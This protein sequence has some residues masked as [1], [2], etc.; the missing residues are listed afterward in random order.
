MAAKIFRSY[1][2]ST[3]TSSIQPSCNKHH[4]V[5]AIVIIIIITNDDD[6]DDDDFYII[7]AVW[8]GCSS[9]LYSVSPS[10]LYSKD[11]VVSP[12]SG[13]FCKIRSLDG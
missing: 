11:F 7:G 9:F 6:D 13:H 5:I 10:L 8:F 3:T 2:S 1:W 12:V 4:N